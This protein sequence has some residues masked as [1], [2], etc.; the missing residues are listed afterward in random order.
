MPDGSYIT[1]KNHR[2]VARDASGRI[3]QERRFFVPDDG[4]LE[5]TVYQVEVSDPAAHVRYICNLSERVCRLE[6]FFARSPVPE[7]VAGTSAIKPDGSGFENLGTQ[8][9]VGLE[10]IGT[11]ETRLIATATIGNEAPILEKREYWYS[12]QLGMNLI[13]R[14]EDPR[15]SSRQNFEVSDLTLGEPDA[16]LFNPPSDFRIVDL[17]KPP[18]ISSSQPSPLN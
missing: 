6:Q 8:T 9:V 10:T 15:F 3:F 2:T 5:S 18:E 17:R 12:P 13:T 1:L 11:R 7:P 16:K 14:R 4:R